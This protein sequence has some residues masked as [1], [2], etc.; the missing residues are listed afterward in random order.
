MLSGWVEIRGSS[1]PSIKVRML[2]VC[3][4][5]SES[6]SFPW[7]RESRLIRAEANSEGLDS[8][9]RG[10]HGVC[11]RLPV[12]K[13]TTLRLLADGFVLSGKL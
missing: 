5:Q 10:N 1:D 12:G 8:R 11:C 2:R 6:P 9:V 4:L 3:L 13:F 7:Q